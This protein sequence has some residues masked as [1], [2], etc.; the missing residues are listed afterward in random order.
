MLV[1]VVDLS[2]KN[3]AKDL[4]VLRTELE[5]YRTGLSARARVIVA[6]KADQVPDNDTDALDSMKGKLDALRETASKWEESDG[7][8]RTVIPMSAKQRGNVQLLVD[9]LV[10]SLQT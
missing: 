1:Y 7:V 9:S 2:G 4:E 3:P 8:H 5:E 10:N 6:N